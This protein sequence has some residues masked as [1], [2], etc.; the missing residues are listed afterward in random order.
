MPTIDNFVNSAASGIELDLARVNIA[1]GDAKP[2]YCAQMRSFWREKEGDTDAAVS[3]TFGLRSLLVDAKARKV[4]VKGGSTVS[5][6]APVLLRLYARPRLYDTVRSN[7]L[8][9]WD[10]NVEV[11]GELTPS[12]NASDLLVAP[13]SAWPDTTADDI[14]VPHLRLVDGRATVE[15]KL[16]GNLAKLLGF[17]AAQSTLFGG[18]SVIATG[19]K[20]KAVL[21]PEGIEFEGSLPDPTRD[22]TGGK[23]TDRIAGTFRLEC[24][25][26]GAQ[27]QYLLRLVRADL[28]AITATEDR[29]AEALSGLLSENAPVAVR[30]DKR[31]VVPPL[32]WTLTHVATTLKLKPTAADPPDFEMQIA[33]T[34]VDVRIRTQGPNEGEGGLA[35]L[36][37]KTVLWK[38]IALQDVEL[39]IGAGD[40][41]PG[42]APLEI[43]FSKQ[44]K[45]WTPEIGDIVDRPYSVP[46]GPVA[47]RL[48]PIY[49]AG[50]GISADVDHAPYVFLPVH[51]GWLQIAIGAAAVHGTS[52]VTPSSG[53]AMSGRI[54]VS[55]EMSNLALLIDDADTIRLKVKWTG[56]PVPIVSRVTLDTGNA[57]GQL[58]GFLHAAETSPSP[59]EV[60]PT[61]RGGPAATRDLP[62]WFG[63]DAPTPSFAGQFSWLASTGSFSAT[64]TL[65]PLATQ[66]LDERPSALAWLP[67]GS[68]PFIASVPLTRTVPSAPDPSASRGLIPRIIDHGQTIKL[69]ST[70]GSVLPTLSADGAKWYSEPVGA[71][72]HSLLLPTLA[73]TEF[74]AT[75]SDASKGMDQAR[76]RFD[77]PILDELF[78]WSDPPRKGAVAQTEPTHVSPPTA[79]EPARL[80]ATWAQSFDRIALTRTQDSDLSIWIPTESESSVDVKALVAPFKWRTKLAIQPSLPDAWGRYSLDSGNYRLDSAV[81]GL[82]GAQ[83]LSF[84]IDG[85][86]IKPDADGDITVAGNAANLFSHTF[87]AG[88]REMIWDLR[89]FGLAA[90]P[91]NGLRAAGQMTLKNATEVNVQPILLRTLKAL[92]VINPDH[93]DG[94]PWRFENP[95]SIH[96]RDLPTIGTTFDGTDN[97][98]ENAVGTN[99]QAFDAGNFATSLHEWRLFQTNSGAKRHDI[100]WGPFAFKPLRLLKV[101]FDENDEPV[102][103]SVIGSMRFS[104]SSIA[105]KT[106]CTEDGPFEQDDVYLRHDLFEL[107][108]T[109]KDGKWSHAWRGK[110]VET[111]GG[112]VIFKPRDSEVSLDVELGDGTK[113]SKPAD[114][115]GFLQWDGDVAASIKLNIVTSEAMI[116]ARLFGFDHRLAG[117]ATPNTAGFTVDLDIEG[118]QSP[119]ETRAMFHVSDAKVRVE[120]SDR[121]LTINGLIAIHPQEP[122]DGKPLKNNLIASIDGDGSCWIGVAGPRQPTRVEHATGVFTWRGQ[123]TINTATKL[124]FRFEA[125]TLELKAALV[126]IADSRED[127]VK[128]LGAVEI[129]SAWAQ[130]TLIDLKQ[131]NARMDY[132]LLASKSA[133]RQHS[134]DIT[135]S[136]SIDSPIAWLDGQ[137]CKDSTTELPPEWLDPAKADQKLR[138]RTIFID[139]D[140]SKRLRHRA[141]LQLRAHRVDV[142]LLMVMDNIV[143]AR[144]PV[145][146]LAITDHQLMPLTQPKPEKLRARWTTLDHI[147]ITSR[148]LM[149]L[150]CK[151]STFA[152]IE[153]S[154]KYRGVS[155]GM[156]RN[157]I[158]PFNLAEAGF[159]DRALAEGWW[160]EDDDDLIIIGGAAVQFPDPTVEGLAFTAVF[161]WIDIRGKDEKPIADLNM[162]SGEW[163]VASADLWPATPMPSG[164]MSVVV[165]GA[166]SEGPA[167]RDQFESRRLMSAEAGDIAPEDVIPVEQAFLERSTAGAVELAAAPFFLRA[168]MAV[169]ARI[170]LDPPASE[171]GVPWNATTIEACRFVQNDTGIIKPS[172]SARRVKVKAENSPVGNTHET[173]ATANLVVLSRRY[174]TELAGYRRIAPEVVEDIPAHALRDEIAELATNIHAAALMAVRVATLPRMLPGFVWRAIAPTFGAVAA[175]KVLTAGRN[176]IGPSAALGWPSETGTAD[177]Y[178]FVPVL[179]EELPVLG[180]EAGLSARFQMLGWPAYAP[181]WR[182]VSAPA[183]GS[184]EALYLSFGHHIVYDRDGTK[185]LTFDGPPARHLLPA[186]ARRRAPITERTNDVLRAVLRTQQAGADAVPAT[187]NVGG[188]RFAAPILPPSVERG[189]VGRRPGVM[190]AVISSMTIPGDRTAFDPMHD[191]FGRPA[192]S[193]PVVAHQLRNPRSPI[194]PRDEIVAVNAEQIA[195]MQRITFDLRR[196]TYVSMADCDAKTGKVPLFR[197]FDGAA[198]IIRIDTDGVRHDRVTFSPVD[199]ALVGPGWNGAIEIAIETATFPVGTDRTGRKLS[200]NAWVEI[201]AE[202]FPANLGIAP[203]GSFILDLEAPAATFILK[204][205]EPLNANEALRDANADTVIRIVLD[206]VDTRTVDGGALLPAS[207]RWQCVLPLMLDPGGRRVLPVTTKTIV[208]GD[209]SY[210]RQLASQ[211]AGNRQAIKFA[212][213][214]VFLLS[215]D[216]KEYDLGLTLRFAGGFIKQR[217]GE[218]KKL[219]GFPNYELK[220]VRLP[221]RLPN[222]DQPQ[223]EP[224]KF[225]TADLEPGGGYTVNACQAYELP[226]RR[227]VLQS[228]PADACPLTPGDRLQLT[229][230]LTKVVG[231]KENTTSIM[232]T[233][234][235]VADPV[236]APPPRSIR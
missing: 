136:R 74:A 109:H 82:G 175:G 89:G 100:K 183:P 139:G 88:S 53:S 170:A 219:S 206:I 1:G 81:E 34:A 107:A 87:P 154:N 3:E 169:S 37:S 233:L 187:T 156:A 205:K 92:L 218:F 192:N 193:G 27:P 54:F 200:I 152:P 215:A 5:H 122:V 213:D 50:D 24:D 220:L 4:G 185:G 40:V 68:S 112:K 111:D 31:P 12:G 222:G 194:L 7:R 177:L 22:F 166:Q 131:P 36:L 195:E 158:A 146:L 64:I 102:A 124:P 199:R 76:L 114:Y 62:L 58:L 201:G 191:R 85:S 149:A 164:A 221:P 16:T 123:L 231:G 174:A 204:V 30:Y 212:A 20:L 84:L 69:D 70:T 115:T 223:A 151:K 9:L 57:R 39:E 171:D 35:S 188:A 155:S 209:P 176:D 132:Q 67:V 214:E 106:P 120:N 134:L 45:R 208:F 14:R 71:K 189:V 126:F 56:N 59:R 44:A 160:D 21:V 232:V 28:A 49:R 190:E 77:L 135:W 165:I 118:A 2:F 230:T 63:T 163:R 121:V 46:L 83:P 127:A 182:D 125:G 101:V 19:G 10:P 75:T 141:T 52:P 116:S 55:R 33:E 196:R 167:I 13:L 173:M 226:L 168:M 105:G 117:V 207:P 130:A 236:I 72:G 66:E 179:G 228:R 198:D 181:E 235:I 203:D 211:A 86:A 18:L 144:E 26:R 210:D 51:E 73:G 43:V 104:P 48:L 60:L 61:L 91:D 133:N 15:V 178:R 41:V 197:P 97:P 172:F 128:T 138:S 184:A 96:L 25:T 180:H 42:S 162:K 129:G 148:R 6:N 157:G 186:V 99:G 137:I 150:E 119:G 47:E 113:S 93:D 202:V 110:A 90:A 229:A 159:H 145:R 225:D 8:Y 142:D 32:F 38:R 224:L 29:I 94:A 153:A 23:S 80:A 147:V 11:E 227:L 143:R 234:D 79:L 108:L 95:I 98:V 78:A 140:A 103:I 161:P 65:P 216:R 17:S 217:S